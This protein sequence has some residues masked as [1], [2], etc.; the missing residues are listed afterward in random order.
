MEETT[1]PKTKFY[2]TE[3]AQE[4][5][6]IIEGQD[7]SISIGIARAGRTDIFNRRVTVKG[8]MDVAEG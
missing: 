5:I 4:T 2:Q 7:G 6:A 8:G 1:T 3:N